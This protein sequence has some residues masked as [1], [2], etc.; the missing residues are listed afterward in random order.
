MQID[1]NFIKAMFFE[2]FQSMLKRWFIDNR[3]HWFRNK[4]S[5]RPQACSAPAAITIAFIGKLL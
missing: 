4:M 3:D 1:D 5:Q 2:Q